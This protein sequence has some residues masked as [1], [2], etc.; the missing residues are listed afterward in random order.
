M[1]ANNREARGDGI[2]K[3]KGIS[4]YIL[5]SKIKGNWNESVKDVRTD[6][7]K[8]LGPLKGTILPIYNRT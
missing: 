6:L 3:L 2:D 8:G 4:Y 7:I 1:Q 5:L